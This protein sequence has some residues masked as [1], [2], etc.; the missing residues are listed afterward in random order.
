M[1]QSP[2]DPIQLHPVAVRWT[3]QTPT[4]AKV[5]VTTPGAWLGDIA[6]GKDKS[7]RV[8]VVADLQ[9]IQHHHQ[10]TKI[11]SANEKS[12]LHWGRHAVQS[13]QELWF[14]ILMS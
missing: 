14:R 8:N 4:S 11:E 2:K 13:H 9:L 1:R 3:S 12:E 7:E 10:K 5:A 6:S